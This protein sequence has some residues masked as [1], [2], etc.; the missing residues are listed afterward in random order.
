MRKVRHSVIALILCLQTTCQSIVSTLGQYIYAS[1]LQTYPSAANRTQHASFTTISKVRITFSEDACTQNSTD[2]ELWAQEQSAD[3][4]FR[5]DLWNSCPMIIMTYL[6]GIYT[7]RLGRHVVLI[8]PMIGMFCQLA[9]WLAVIDEQLDEF[10]WCIASFLVGLSGSS[11]IS[12]KQ[13]Q[14]FFPSLIFLPLKILFS[15]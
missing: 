7:P 11:N 1:Y 9:I 2:A 15:F 14:T 13:N 3:L 8:L 4:F 6:L 12:S 5:I 10:W